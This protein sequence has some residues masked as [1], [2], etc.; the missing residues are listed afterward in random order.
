MV[1][2]WGQNI[3]SDTLK[4]SIHPEKILGIILDDYVRK[5]DYRLSTVGNIMFYR[6]QIFHGI[7][8]EYYPCTE[9]P[10][11]MRRIGIFKDGK[12]EGIFK[13]YYESGELLIEENYSNGILISIPKC[14]DLNGNEIECKE[15]SFIKPMLEEP[16]W[17][18]TSIGY[19]GKLHTN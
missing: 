7:Y 3:S 18:E 8:G 19:N 12:P 15:L 17:N 9:E 4:V 13:G 5:S 14:L 2:G 1:M 10:G 16:Y 11:K 6:D